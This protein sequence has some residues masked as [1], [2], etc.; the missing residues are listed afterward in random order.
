MKE[1][2]FD[3]FTL[4]LILVTM[5]DQSPLCE[6]YIDLESAG[7]ASTEWGNLSED[8]LEENP[9]RYHL[10]ESI[11][12]FEGFKIM[13][14]FIHD[15]VEDQTVKDR[16]SEALAGKRPFRRFK[17][18]MVDFPALFDRYEHYKNQIMLDNLRID[19]EQQGVQL[20][21]TKT[22]PNDDTT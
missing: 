16:L 3:Q 17:D 13:E 14:R 21:V 8:D 6:M 20:V 9:E 22:P 4:D 1:V 19:L 11:L 2:K 12:P 15:E 5:E 7:I 10:I 18:V